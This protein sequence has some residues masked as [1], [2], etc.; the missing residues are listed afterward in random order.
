MRLYAM[1]FLVAF[2]ALPALA[3]YPQNEQPM[4]GGKPP[5]ALQQRA[6]EEFIAHAVKMA[7]S[8]EAGAQ[9]SVQLGW[10]YF[11]EKQDLATAMKRF[12]QAY[13]LDPENGGAYQGM[14]IIVLTRDKDAAQAEAL[15]K[16]GISAKR[17]TP[18][19]FVDYARFLLMQQ[20]PAD[21]EKML[22]QAV[23]MDPNYAES[24]TLLAMAQYEA[25]H[26]EDACVRAEQWKD[27]AKEGLKQSLQKLAESPQC[28]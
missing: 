14:A 13:L 17:I 10:K 7:G 6:D 15:F 24:Q 21:A 2:A 22:L 4:Y 1:M 12:N 3:E 5:N 11:F 19:Q 9:T 23:D 20:R 18:D 27:K 16:R 26:V 8:K 28:N 25:G